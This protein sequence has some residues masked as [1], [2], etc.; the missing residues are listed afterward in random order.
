MKNRKEIAKE[1]AKTQKAREKLL[2]QFEEI[3]GLITPDA[4]A[5]TVEK[6]HSWIA[7]NMV[8]RVPLEEKE[9]HLFDQNKNAVGLSQKIQAIAKKISEKTLEDNLSDES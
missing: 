5:R 7:Y 2:K 4:L 1:S 8:H 3:D 6:I 9:I